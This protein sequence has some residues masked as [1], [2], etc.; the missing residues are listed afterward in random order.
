MIYEN[1]AVSETIPFLKLQYITFIYLITYCLRYMMDMKENITVGKISKNRIDLTE[2]RFRIV[3]AMLK[4]DKELTRRVKA[5]LERL[6][7]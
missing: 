5:Y 2:I 3:V 6:T 7:L 4:I 1:L